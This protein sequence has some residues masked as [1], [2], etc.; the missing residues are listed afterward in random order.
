MA[1]E[2]AA[3]ANNAEQCR[4]CGEMLAYNKKDC[5]WDNYLSR[6]SQRNKLFLIRNKGT[7]GDSTN[8][9]PTVKMVA[10]SR[11][12]YDLLVWPC[13]ADS[14]ISPLPLIPVGNILCH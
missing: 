13:I 11:A 3:L 10:E 6:F 9:K 2:T 5:F 8:K 12:T 1:F 14:I 4:G 7:E